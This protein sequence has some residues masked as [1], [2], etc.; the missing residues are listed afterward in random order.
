M[1]LASNS[2]RDQWWY[3]ATHIPGWE[4]FNIWRCAIDRAGI[5][6]HSDVYSRMWWNTACTMGY[7]DMER[8]IYV[9]VQ[10]IMEKTS[11][12]ANS[13]EIDAYNAC[14]TCSS[15]EPPNVLITRRAPSGVHEEL[16]PDN[17]R[18]YR[19]TLKCRRCSQR[20]FSEWGTRG[21]P[22]REASHE[23]WSKFGASWKL[24]LCPDCSST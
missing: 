14:S 4:H 20:W 23:G 13:V 9:V 16:H 17:G 24:H 2:E 19:L 21:A 22:Y 10:D 12:K 6:Q 5:L 7:A 1:H 3:T 18:Y 11:V 15:V 8:F